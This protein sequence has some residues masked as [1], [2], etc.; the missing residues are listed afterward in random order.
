MFSVLLFFIF[1]NDCRKKSNLNVTLDTSNEVFL[2]IVL[3]LNDYFKN[4]K[5]N[6]FL[7]MKSTSGHL[8]IA[9]K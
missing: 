8:R 6:P 2:H 4:D 7:I 1:V 5:M 9:E 3:F